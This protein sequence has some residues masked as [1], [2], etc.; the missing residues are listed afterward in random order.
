MISFTGGLEAAKAIQRKAELK[1]LV[2]ELGSNSLVIVLSDADLEEAVQYCVSAAF[3]ASG[4]NC[5]GVK[6][7]L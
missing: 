4:Q 6:R 1:K 3:Y 7:I 5:V 2:M